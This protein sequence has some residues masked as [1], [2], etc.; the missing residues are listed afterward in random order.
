MEKVRVNKKI[1]YTFK[2]SKEMIEF[3]LDKS[4]ILV[5]VGVEKLLNKDAKLT[6][7][8]NNNIAYCDGVGVVM[9]LKKKGVKA[10]KIPGS[11]LWLDLI[12]ETYQEKT[13]YL[14]GAKEEVIILTADKLKANF[15]GIDILKYRNGYF[16]EDDIAQIEKEL[17]MLKPDIVFVALGSPKQEY[18]MDRFS[19]KHKAL[20]MG[21]GGSFDIYVTKTKDVPKYWKKIFKWEGIYRSYNDFTNFRRWKRQLIAFRFFYKLWFTKF[22]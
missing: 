1:I 5:A 21:L 11:V 10:E 7:I 13:F 17:L 9:A 4:K 12:N 2:S 8:I 20:Y 22:N 18:L 14:F 6:E 19:R 3:V 16:G 15:P